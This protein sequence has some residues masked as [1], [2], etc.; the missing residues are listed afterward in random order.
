MA[1]NSKLPISLI[2]LCKIQLNGQLLE[3]V[4]RLEIKS[5]DMELVPEAVL[6]IIVV[7]ADI[8]DLTPAVKAWLKKDGYK[9][10]AGE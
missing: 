7:N 2:G 3:A 10:E 1:K 8:K 9:D 5:A 6:P 4:Q